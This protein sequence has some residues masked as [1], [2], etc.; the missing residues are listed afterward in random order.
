MSCV[1]E[2]GT[3]RVFAPPR[4]SAPSLTCALYCGEDDGFSRAGE[5]G[6]SG[7]EQAPGL[8]FCL[9]SAVGGS[10]PGGR[11][12]EKKGPAA[13]V[14]GSQQARG[15]ERTIAYTPRVVFT[16]EAEMAAGQLGAQGFRRGKENTAQ[17]TRLALVLCR[18]SQSHILTFEIRRRE[19]MQLNSTDKEIQSPQYGAAYPE[20]VQW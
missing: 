18:I 9:G 5:S 6:D 10:P 8:F 1:K 20:S 11:R 3:E 12:A 16:S 7:E 15:E 2:T 14:G 4:S 19:N 13:D 17:N